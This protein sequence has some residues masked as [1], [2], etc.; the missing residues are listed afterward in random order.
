M[1]PLVVGFQT[2]PKTAGVEYPENYRLPAFSVRKTT[3][4]RSREARV[5]DN[6]PFSGPSPVR[7]VGLRTLTAGARPGRWFCAH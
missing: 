4:C 5:C 1:A 6:S 2:A 7:T 3:V